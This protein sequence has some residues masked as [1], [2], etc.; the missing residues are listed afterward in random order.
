MTPSVP[1][2]TCAALNTSGFCPGE[3]SIISPD[4][5]TRVMPSTCVDRVPKCTPVPCVPVLIAP[6]MLCSSMSPRFSWARPRS[7]SA[8]P[9]FLSRVPP[10]TVAVPR[11]VSIA[12]IPCICSSDMSTSLVCTSGVKEWP[13]PATRTWRPSRPYCPI[14]C[15]SSSILRGL[16]TWCGVHFTEPDQLL[17]RSVCLVLMG[18]L[19]PSYIRICSQATTFYRRGRRK[20]PHHPSAPPPPLRDFPIG[21][22]GHR[23]GKS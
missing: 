8:F 12:S 17:Q 2:D 21:N 11:V 22:T 15:A 5:V 18:T 7:K 14:I 13:E 10:H 4:A 1:S 20:R 6:V 16:T 3:H 19:L 9:R 23:H